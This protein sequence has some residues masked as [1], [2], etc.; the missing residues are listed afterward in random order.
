MFLIRMPLTFA[1]YELTP[2]WKIPKYSYRL[3][4]GIR[5]VVRHGILIPTF[6]GSNP[7]CP[8]IYPVIN[9]KKEG[10][11]KSKKEVMTIEYRAR[12]KANS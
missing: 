12:N 6:V 3:L 9:R 8:V 4:M 7:T 10:I 2:K 5:Q 11:V 1:D